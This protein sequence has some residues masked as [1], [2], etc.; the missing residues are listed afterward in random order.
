MSDRDYCVDC[1]GLLI[2]IGDQCLAG[3]LPD[4]FCC[5]EEE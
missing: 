3:D 5:C 4:F 2:C 1:G